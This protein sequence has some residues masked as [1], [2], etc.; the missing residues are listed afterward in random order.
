MDLTNEEFF[1]RQTVVLSMT[2]GASPG[3]GRFAGFCAGIRQHIFV[4][5]EIK[6]SNKTAGVAGH[7]GELQASTRVLESALLAELS[8]LEKGKKLASQQPGF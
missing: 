1:S 2:E 3:L 6:I 7:F 5:T 8:D 4:A